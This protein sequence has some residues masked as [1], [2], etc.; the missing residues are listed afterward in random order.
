MKPVFGQT[1]LT[2]LAYTVGFGTGDLGDFISK[3]SF[4]GATFE[5]H[6]LVKPNLGVG[7]E[8]GWSAFYE[9]SDYATYTDGTESISGKQFRYCSTVPIMASANYYFKPG[10]DFNPFAGVGVGTEFSR[11]DLD[12][13][14]YTKQVNTWH[15]A[16]KPE[17]GVIF[18]VAATTGVVVSAKYYNAFKT[19][20]IGTRSYV[21]ANVGLVWGY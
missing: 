11:S 17:V 15:F 6:R 4:R 16:V 5:Y 21:A 8:T 19:A 18:R 1:Q 7:F 10:E 20:E 14:V 13:G 3:P 9:E 2:S 12:M